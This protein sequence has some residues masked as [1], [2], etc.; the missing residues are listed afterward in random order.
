MTKQTP[1]HVRFYRSLEAFP[2]LKREG[3]A[4]TL[5]V[6]VSPNGDEVGSYEFAIE[7][8]GSERGSRPIALRA[9]LFAS[10]W[11]AFVDLPEF[12]TLLA[13][14][15]ESQTGY[16]HIS[17]D[18]LIPLLLNLGWV[19]QTAQYAAGRWYPRPIMFGT[20]TEAA[21]C[22][23]PNCESHGKSPCEG[24]GCDGLDDD[25]RIALRG[26]ASGPVMSPKCHPHT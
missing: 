25:E 2:H 1:P 8:V 17:L 9:Q 23:H 5:W 18:D 11:R 15:D 16:G 6:N 3:R 24:V 20:M 21:V 22:S 14:L 7:H 10:S 26:L 19:D 12:F 4:D 13:S